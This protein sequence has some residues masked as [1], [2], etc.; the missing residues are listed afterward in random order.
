[1]STQTESYIYRVGQQM[2]DDWEAPAEDRVEWNY[3]YGIHSIT[4]TYFHIMPDELLAFRHEITRFAFTIAD[5]V[6]FFLTRLGHVPFSD[7]PYSWHKLTPEQ[8]E[9]GLPPEITNRIERALVI[10]IIIEGTTRRIAALRQVYLSN[11]MTRL[12]HNAIRQQAAQGW[13]GD[14]AHEATISRVYTEYPTQEELASSAIVSCTGEDNPA[15]EPLRS[16]S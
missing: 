14:E 2:P 9:A 4:C 7:N 1:M 13:E 12:L 11:E 16:T 5:N 15:T 10:I 8:Q 3:R 6:I